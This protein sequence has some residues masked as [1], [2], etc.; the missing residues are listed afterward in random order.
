MASDDEDEFLR[1]TLPALGLVH[2]RA[3]IVID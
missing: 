1:A 2:N 3:R